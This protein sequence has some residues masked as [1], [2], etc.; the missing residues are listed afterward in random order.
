MTAATHDIS[1]TGLEKVQK[2]LELKITNLKN[3]RP[4]KARKMI[5]LFVVPD[6]MGAAFVTQKITGAKKM[7]H[8][9]KKTAQY[10]LVLSETEVF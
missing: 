9:D 1:I 3:L 6:T 7:R 4:T 5:I 10:V 2:S 8:W